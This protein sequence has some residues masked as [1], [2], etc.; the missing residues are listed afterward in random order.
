MSKY[1]CSQIKVSQL[2]M[3]KYLANRLAYHTVRFCHA[4]GV[5]H[6]NIKPENILCGFDQVY[7]TDFGLATDLRHSTNKCGTRAYMSP[8][9]LGSLDTSLCFYNTFANNI[10]SLGF[11]LMNLL[12]SARPWREAR[13]D[14]P[15]FRTFVAQDTTF[16]NPIGKSFEYSFILKM[17]CLEDRQMTA[18]QVL[19][20]LL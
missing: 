2:L 12:G 15:H 14:D 10:W 18:K 20:A 3:G 1:T 4:Q 13:S 9:C 7:L 8:E 11:V 5:A 16:F 19:Q 6:C 17:L